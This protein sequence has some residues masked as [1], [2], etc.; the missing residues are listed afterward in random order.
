MSGIA[1]AF[2]FMR[3]SG[4]A[5]GSQSYTSAGTFSWVAPAGVTKVSVLVVGSGVAGGGAFSKIGGALS[6]KNNM[7]VT[8]GNSY[9]V[10]VRCAGA[11]CKNYFCST[12]VVSAAYGSCRTGC[13]GGNGGAGG[14]TYGGGGGAGGYSGTGGAGGCN[15]NGSN[16]AGGGGG[17]G[18]NV[19]NCGYKGGGGGGGVGLLGQGSNGVGGVICGIFGKPGTGGSCGATGTQGFSSPGFSLGG[20]GGLYGGGGGGSNTSQPGGGSRGAVRIVWPGSARTFP[21][22]CVGSP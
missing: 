19:C 1:Q 14:G 17:G 3:S 15:A 16:G 10:V 12:S 13:G 22:T 20:C 7:S 8:P 5:P 9:T 4:V 21:S 11:L 6:Y 2:G 18:A